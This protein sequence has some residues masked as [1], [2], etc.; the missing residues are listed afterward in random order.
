M[1]VQSAQRE[2]V[3]TR[4][5]LHGSVAHILDSVHLQDLSTINR[6]KVINATTFSPTIPPPKESSHSNFVSFLLLSHPVGL[7]HGYLRYIYMECSHRKQTCT[8][9]TLCMLPGPKWR[10]KQFFSR[11]TSLHPSPALA[12][13]PLDPRVSPAE[14]LCVLSPLIPCLSR[15]M[16]RGKPG[17][18]D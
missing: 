13:D 1:W 11:P 14:V 17:L 18:T 5:R 10:C 2:G 6:M 15:L 3:N 9:I 7:I 8:R 12:P 16:V 4:I